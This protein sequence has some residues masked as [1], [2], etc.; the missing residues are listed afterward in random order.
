[1]I[2]PLPD[3][4]VEPVVRAALAEDLGRGGDVTSA[5]LIPAGARLSAV[6]A[7]RAEGRM[8]GL[9]CARLA[10][11]AL[12]PAVRF[13]AL[14]A[15]GEDFAAGAVLARVEADARA[16]LAA[17]RVALNFLGRLCGVATLTRAYVR[18]TAGTKARIVCTRKTTPGLRLLE[19][20]AVRC[21]GGVNHRFGL[22]DAILIKDN[23]IAALAAGH[24]RP[25][26]EAVARAKAS[27]GHLMQVEVEVDTLEQ[28]DEALSAAPDVIM[29]DNFSLD[30]PQ[31]SRPPHRR[32]RRA[33][34]LRRRHPFDRES[35]RPNRRRRHLR[36]RPNPLRP[37]PRHRPGRA[38][39][40]AAPFEL[41]PEGEGGAPPQVGTMRGHG[42]AALSAA[43]SSFS[44]RE[45]EAPPQVGTMR[46]YGA[47]L[48]SAVHDAIITPSVFCRTSWFQNRSTVQPA[49]SSTS[50]RACVVA[51]LLGVLSTVQFDHQPT[52]KAGEV[53]DEPADRSLPAELAALELAVAQMRPEHALGIR[54][55]AAQLSRA[56]RP[57][58]QVVPDHMAILAGHRRAP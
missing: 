54:R 20:Y 53:G 33:R 56:Q 12:D 24:E 44:Q 15:D 5:A 34:S 4:L 41:L 48:L 3:V 37:R 32:R 28:L 22:D 39:L 19:K 11:A 29:L 7:A 18:E 27:A 51:D 1:M 47:A 36:R 55:Q 10:I 26:A 21:G 31:R 25:V 35:H 14:V 57:R 46:G 17:E 23:H 50:V 49:A 30:G 43:C 2:A 40:V 42:A 16:L 52:L 13:E 58:L 6:F 45:K 8:A 9:A 38:A